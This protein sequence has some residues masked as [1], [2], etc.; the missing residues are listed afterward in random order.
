M[1]EPIRCSLVDV[2]QRVCRMK[3]AASGCTVA[4]E[5]EGIPILPLATGLLLGG[6]AG[7]VGPRLELVV[8]IELLGRE[9]D[10]Q[11]WL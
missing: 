1:A 9:P 10:Y 6:G 7:A 2:E 5:T 4:G 3:R 11:L 8:A